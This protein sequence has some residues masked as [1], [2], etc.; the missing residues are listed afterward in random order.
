MATT[1]EDVQV[2]C[3][4]FGLTFIEAPEEPL[5]DAEEWPDTACAGFLDDPMYCVTAIILDV[6]G[7]C[8]VLDQCSDPDAWPARM[9]DTWKPRRPDEVRQAIRTGV[10]LHPRA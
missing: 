7:T 5:D 10:P 4:T 1:K 8:Q 2:Y 9:E 3:A 6:D